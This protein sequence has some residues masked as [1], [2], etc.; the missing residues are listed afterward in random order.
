MQADLASG[1][2]RGA[3]DRLGVRRG[4]EATWPSP[5]GSHEAQAALT[6][7]RRPR[8][9]AHADA[10]WGATWAVNR[11]DVTK[12]IGESTTLF[13]LVLSLYSFRVG[14]CSHTISILQ[15]TWLQRTRQIQMYGMDR[16]DPSPRDQWLQHVLKIRSKWTWS[17]GSPDATWQ[18]EDR[19]IFIKAD[20]ARSRSDRSLHLKI[21]PTATTIH[22]R[23]SRSQ[24][25]R[26]A[27]AARSSRNQGV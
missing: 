27:I 26:T 19:R 6:R 23:T 13:N 3:R 25:D 8:R 24:L 4:T 22:G 5:G 2:W 20:I 1:G 15:V 9:R 14:L 12:L 16:V 7:G 10:V 21:N 11:E 17:M 18:H